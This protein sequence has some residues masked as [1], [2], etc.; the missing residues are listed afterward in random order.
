MSFSL[1]VIWAFG[2]SFLDLDGAEYCISTVGWCY[3]RPKVGTN[4]V[5]ADASRSL[6]GYCGWKPQS[7]CYLVKTKKAMYRGGHSALWFELGLG[8]P[9]GLKLN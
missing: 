3:G 5:V 4:E 1:L 6:S 9:L 7:L 8:V 2:H